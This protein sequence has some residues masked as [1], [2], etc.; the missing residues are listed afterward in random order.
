MTSPTLSVEQPRHRF[1]FRSGELLAIALFWAFIAGMTVASR[2]LDPRPP[3]QPEVVTNALVRLALT[4]YLIW[5]ALTIPIFWLADRARLDGP[6]RIAV[7]IGMI[8][9][10]LAVAVGVDSIIASMRAELFAGIRPLGRGFRRPP[11]GLGGTRTL[12]F[13][14]DF[15]VYIAVFSTGVAR[16]YVL[17]F[18][19]RREESARL[20]AQK[21]SLE[22]R[23]AEARLT[24]LQAQLDPHFLFNTLHAVSALVERD[25]S[26]VRR[27]ISRLSELLRHTLESNR[28]AEVSLQREVALARQYID[29]MRI[30]FQGQL[31]MDIDA[32]EQL[33][34]ALVP[35]LILQPLIENAIKHGA[36]KVTSG[37][38]RA[39]VARDDGDLVIRVTDNGPGV[40]NG[41][42]PESPGVGLRNTRER[43]AELYGTRQSLTLQPGS[44]DGTVVE[45]RL[46]YHTVPIRPASGVQAVLTGDRHG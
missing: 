30:R 20:Q 31:Q 42:M 11:F 38:V 13:L 26:G 39:I 12:R 46:P 21:A 18:Q 16:S 17:R 15:I 5:A 3:N 33:E 2:L 35:Q 23:L 22:A 24:A 32:P 34:N 8:A 19:A 29:I 1:A 7:A 14:D 37:H 25:P 45:V 36:S 28:E 44:P 6:N 10:G 43:L 27:M 9:I 40:T 4:E 41:Q